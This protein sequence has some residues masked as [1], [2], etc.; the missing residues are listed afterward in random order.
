MKLFVVQDETSGRL[1]VIERG[2]IRL[3]LTENE[4]RELQNMLIYELLCLAAGRGK[5]GGE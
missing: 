3:C 1:V 4:A 2:E 5:D